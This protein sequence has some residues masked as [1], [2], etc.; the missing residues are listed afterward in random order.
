MITKLM[1]EIKE[2]LEIIDEIL[3]KENYLVTYEK[4]LKYMKKEIDNRNEHIKEQQARIDKAIAFLETNE[5]YVTVMY[6][7]VYEKKEELLDILKGSD[8]K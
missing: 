5:Y 7:N 6:D 4:S 1:Q 3:Q 2:K 8:I